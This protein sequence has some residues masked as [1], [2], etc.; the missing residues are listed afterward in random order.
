[1]A[2]VDDLYDRAPLLAKL[3]FSGPLPHTIA[4]AKVSAK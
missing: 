4:S 3:P 2:M 1:M